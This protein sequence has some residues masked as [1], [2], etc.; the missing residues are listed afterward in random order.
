MGCTASECAGA[1]G[2]IVKVPLSPLPQQVGEI[3]DTYQGTGRF[4]LSRTL[5][6]ILRR[7]GFEESQEIPFLGTTY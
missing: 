6:G 4:Y 7:S 1:F 3:D 5:S 2:G